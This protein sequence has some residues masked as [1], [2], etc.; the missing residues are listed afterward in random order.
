[1]KGGQH[2]CLASQQLLCRYLMRRTNRKQGG[3]K[4]PGAILTYIYGHNLNLQLFLRDR[5]TALMIRYGV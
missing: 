3:L 5:F 4:F 1:M 2:T